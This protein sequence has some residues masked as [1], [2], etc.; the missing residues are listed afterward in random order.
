V[1]IAVRAYYDGSGADRNGRRKRITLAGY[2]A[3][4]AVWADIEGKW[5]DVL[6]DDSRRPSCR[7]LHM[8]EAN[9]LV[10]EFSSERGWTHKGV[11]ILLADL[12]NICLAPHGWYRP[13]GEGLFGAMC[14]V[15]LAGYEKACETI[16]R[17][18]DVEPLGGHPKPAI[19]RHL[20]TGN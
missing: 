14:T 6:A 7:Y 10:G 4:P 16:P 2:A 12:H 19:N 3:S 18:R 20:K 1:A 9:R 13:L 15:E 5:W 11:D 8:R 17:L